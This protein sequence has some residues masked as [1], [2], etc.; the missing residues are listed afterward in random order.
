MQVCSQ[1]H[2]LFTLL[3]NLPP[4]IFPTNKYCFLVWK[5]WTTLTIKDFAWKNWTYKQSQD[6]LVSFGYIVIDIN[7]NV[8]LEA[9]NLPSYNNILNFILILYLHTHRQ[10]LQENFEPRV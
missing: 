5:N 4:L 7:L 8:K 9:S 6:G 10:E 1:K 3:I 2:F